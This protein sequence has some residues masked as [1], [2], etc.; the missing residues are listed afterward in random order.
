LSE[1]EYRQRT[2]AWVG[3]I[4]ASAI[5]GLTLLTFQEL[6]RAGFPLISTPEI[7]LPVIFVS[8]ITVACYVSVIARSASPQKTAITAVITASA[9]GIFNFI[10]API[11][12]LPLSYTKLADQQKHLADGIFIIS[13]LSLMLAIIGIMQMETVEERKIGCLW[14]IGIIAV[15]LVLLYLFAQR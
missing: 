14:M 7:Y 2:G 11:P 9:T 3:L 15:G 6:T 12:L 5:A 8:L 13:G 4:F 1:T 10:L